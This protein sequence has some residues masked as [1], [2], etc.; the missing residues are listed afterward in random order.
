[1][2]TPFLSL[3]AEANFTPTSK[4][5]PRLRKA[6]SSCLLEDSS[7]SATSRGKPSM[8]VTSE[9]NEFHTDANSH[10]MTPPPKT[11]TDLGT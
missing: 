10:P 1:M 2:V 5:I 7:S 4:L 8:I 6:R 9:P 3:A 11:M